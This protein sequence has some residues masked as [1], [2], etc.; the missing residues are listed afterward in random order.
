M[1]VANVLEGLGAEAEG[2]QDDPGAE[3]QEGNYKFS[4]LNFINS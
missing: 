1:V 3:V 2:T 4:Y